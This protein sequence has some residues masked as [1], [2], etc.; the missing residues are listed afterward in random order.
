MTREAAIKVFCQLLDAFDKSEHGDYFY[1]FGDMVCE[2]ANVAISALREQES[3]AE[4]QATSDKTNADHI[5]SMTDDELA[6]FLECFGV[7][8]YCS[9]HERLE[10]E[11]LLKGERCDEQCEQHMLDWL[12]QPYGG[13]T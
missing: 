13:E 11:P 4:K 5:R 10:N 3:L 2:A 1:D 8:H 7:C 12:K 6:V 9:E